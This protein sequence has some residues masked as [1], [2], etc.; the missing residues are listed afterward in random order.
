MMGAGAN[1]L[2]PFPVPPQAEMAK[3]YET[4]G[5]ELKTHLPSSR[6]P[7]GYTAERVCKG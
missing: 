7:M 2:C 1:R 6:T 5:L 3:R 4:T